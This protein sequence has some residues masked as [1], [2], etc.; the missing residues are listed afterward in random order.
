MGLVFRWVD[1]FLKNDLWRYKMPYCSHCGQRVESGERFCSNC[2]RELVATT[3][4]PKGLQR[5]LIK[6]ADQFVKGDNPR[7][8]SLAVFG[9][10]FLCLFLPFVTIS[11]Q[12]QEITTL[13]TMKMVTGT[14][15]SGQ[16]IHGNVLA[17]FILLLVLSGIIL[18]FWKDKLAPLA[19]AGVSF[20]SFILVI[21][22][23]NGINSAVTKEA[24]SQ[25]MFVSIDTRSRAGFYLLFILMLG[26]TAINSFIVKKENILA[27]IRKK[28]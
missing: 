24:S 1:S 19:S 15:I 3:G 5:D 10:A 6:Q 20:L 2:G 4:I 28:E 8:I 18:Y 7:K 9:L 14:N 23:R 11:C 17:I 26:G 13:S 16:S 12:G 25:N 22:L 21:A 27:Q